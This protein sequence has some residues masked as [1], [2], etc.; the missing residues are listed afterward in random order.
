M[1][2]EQESETPEQAEDEKPEGE[3]PKYTL[4]VDDIKQTRTVEDI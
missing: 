1:E 3:K 2:N 4:E